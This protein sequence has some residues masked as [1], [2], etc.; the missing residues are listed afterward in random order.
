VKNLSGSAD[1][2][3]WLMFI[4]NNEM[5]TDAHRVLIETYQSGIN[6]RT[7]RLQGRK[8]TA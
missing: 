4:A 5:I 1:I 6:Q 7:I 2:P 3:E 8:V